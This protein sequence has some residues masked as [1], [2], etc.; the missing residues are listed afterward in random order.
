[1]HLEMNVDEKES[2]FFWDNVAD[3]PSVLQ[4]LLLLPVEEMRNIS[5]IKKTFKINNQ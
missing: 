4:V 5:V 1:M 2:T 3:P